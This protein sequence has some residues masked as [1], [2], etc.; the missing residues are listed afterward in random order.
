MV[1]RVQRRATKLVKSLANL[2]YS[3]RLRELDLPTL[4]YRRQR[5]DIIQL[6]KITHGFDKVRVNNHC[7]LCGRAMFK[8]SLATNTRGHQF[9][10]QIQKATGP[11][12]HF[13]P[14]RVTPAWNK[15]SQTTVNSKTVKEFKTR[16]GQEWGRHPDLFEYKFT[17]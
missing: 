15:L 2:P 14:T 16:L 9:K 1:E 4:H 13:F 3:E 10:Y 17:Y 7:N 8:P 6:F 5:A 12:A 11:R